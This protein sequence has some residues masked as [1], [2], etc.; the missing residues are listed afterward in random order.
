M[1]IARTWFVLLLSLT[2]L[3]PGCTQPQK[4]DDSEAREPA[5][6][7]TSPSDAAF[8]AA[9]QPSDVYYEIFVRSFRDSNGDGIG[10]L[11]GVTEKLDYL[12][13]LG[14]H[15][16]WLMPV[17]P[18]PSYHGYDV[19]DYYGI[20]P[21]YGTI[22]DMKRLLDEAHKRNIKVIMD[23][24]INHTS[25]QHPWFTESAAGEDSP[26]RDW[27]VWADEDTNV[28]ESSATGAAK[29]WY[30]KN[31]AYYL[32]PFWDGMPDL[33]MDNP[34]VRNELIAVGK[35]WLNLGADGFRL[36]AAKHIYDNVA[37][38][39]NNPKTKEKN[40][41]WWQQFRKEMERTKPDVVMVGEV[42]DS[43]AVVAPYFDHAMT[44]AF[45]FDL[46]NRI[47]GMVQSESKSNLA[48][49][50]ER[51]YTLYAEASGGTFSDSTFLSNH[52]QNRVMSVLGGN[53]DHAKM[54]A[55]VLLTLPGNPYLYY[56]EELGMSGM[57]PDEHIREPFPWTKDR[58]VAGNTSWLVPTFNKDG[59]I[60]AEA[61]ME[62]G[63][64]IWNHYKRLIRY[65]NSDRAL[66]EGGIVEF[67]LD[68]AKLESFV[69][70]TE[71][72][73]ASLVVHNLGGEAAE[74]DL[75]QVP[76][77]VTFQSIRFATKDGAVLDE[78]GRLSLPGYATVIIKQE[79]K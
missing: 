9:N 18:S 21:D 23:L 25:S 10:D 22:D 52:D 54:A 78:N 56:G 8:S 45:N 29:A 60:S 35:H 79:N 3:L 58:S 19:T 59:E 70:A 67:K 34:D 32:A 62:D 57:K 5:E 39:K 72:G 77:G 33:N 43:P 53:V 69:R 24:V 15:G 50:L 73:D 51:I 36:D 41:E 27:Y 16:I 38:D 1:R 47:I 7:A 71:D 17:N 13:E 20:N 2:L 26:K 48:F 31:G 49:M 30:P 46:A 64:S 11:N 61:L 40:I 12:K 28:G 4:A 37:S 6:G 76:G 68:N 44:S 75:T 42:W 14:I 65:R 66:Y 55:A 74:A 63:L